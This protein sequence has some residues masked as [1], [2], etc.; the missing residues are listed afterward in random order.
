[1]NIYIL[2][3]NICIRK[4]QQFYVKFQSNT[5]SDNS[6]IRSDNKKMLDNIGY[7]ISSAPLILIAIYMLRVLALLFI[8]IVEYY[9]LTNLENFILNISIDT[10][11]YKICITII[12]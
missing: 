3:E 10:F 8:I 5:S 6:A 11:L 2:L 4:N 9:M 7:R 1:M 12:I